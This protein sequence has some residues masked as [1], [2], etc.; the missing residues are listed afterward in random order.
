MTTENISENFEILT[1]LT[2]RVFR[3]DDT[4]L[5]SEK[6]G[7]IIRYRGQLVIESEKAYDQLKDA[8]KSYDITPLFRLENGVET[9]FLVKGV[10][11]PKPSNPWVNAGL[12]LLTLLSVLFA[13]ALYNYQ[14]PQ[15]DNFITNIKYVFL[16]LGAGWP[17]A[18][19][20]L[21][22]LGAHEFG[23][24]L[25]A[26]YHG[27]NVTLPY[28]IPFPFSPF[29][30]MGA[31]IQMKELPKNK[32]HLMDIGIAGPLAGL[33]VAIPILIFGLATSKINTLPMEF[34]PGQVFE[35]N[36][37]L[38]LSLKYIVLGEWLPKPI[39]FGGISPLL[40]WVRYFFTG[41]P[42]PYGGIDVTVNSVAWAGWAGLLV[43]ALNLIPVGQLDGGHLIYVIFGKRARK[44]VPFI[45]VILLIL[46]VFWSG[47]LLWAFLIFIFGRT[48]AE[49]LDQIT[50]L[51]G[52]RKALAILGIILFVLVFTPVPL[53]GIM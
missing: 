24:Y 41:M 34:P 21:A 17:F 8:L 31:F 33:I 5:G 15:S 14:G 1:T 52:R 23:H 48:Q 51:D 46:G 7:F 53:A 13:G 9:I 36:S 27:T 44:I 40:Y 43:T 12:F 38:Y 39:S 30:T 28:F 22:I 45:L 47:W 25:V 4:T 26:R 10:V 49:P 19:S 42:M 2:R 16:N 3:I 50:Q 18:V 6:Q 32:R 37:I 29:G 20:M 35:G 11:R